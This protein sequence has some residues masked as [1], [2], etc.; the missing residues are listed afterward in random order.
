MV[1]VGI[2]QGPNLNMLGVREPQLYGQQSLEELHRDLIAY[3]ERLNLDVVCYQSNH[4]GELVEFIQQAR[5]KF[6]YLLINAAAYTHTSIAI[7]DAL[8]A[9]EVPAIEIHLSNIYAREDFRHK[10]MLSD[11]VQGQIC[12]LGTLGYKL[13]LE[14][15]AEL[16]KAELLKLKGKNE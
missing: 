6:A 10:S 3:G 8:L 5:G 9:S 14:A 2:V 4:E 1:K 12:G 13:A 11:I 16:L 15:V 7:R